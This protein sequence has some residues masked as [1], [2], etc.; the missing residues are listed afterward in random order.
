MFIIY[1]IPITQK[2]MYAARLQCLIDE[3]EIDASF[4][5]SASTFISTH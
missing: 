4:T 3:L 2:V 1:V 5:L